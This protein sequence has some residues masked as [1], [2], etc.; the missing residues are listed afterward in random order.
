[1]VRRVKSWALI[2]VTTTLLAGPSLAADDASI[3]QD[4]TVVIALHALPCGRVIS[5]VR[6]GDIDYTASCQAG[7]RYRIFTTPAGR[8]AVQKQ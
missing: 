3:R 5:A 8:G 4:L 7:T 6:Q 2:G 1:M